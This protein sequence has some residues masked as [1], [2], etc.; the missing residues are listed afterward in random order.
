MVIIRKGFMRE[1]VRKSDLGAA[2]CS[3]CCNVDTAP[4][5]CK[6]QVSIGQMMQIAYLSLLFMEKPSQACRDVQ[7]APHGEILIFRRGRG[8]ISLS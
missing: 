2:N 8:L 7:E 1:G 3:H 6:E 4:I 5:T